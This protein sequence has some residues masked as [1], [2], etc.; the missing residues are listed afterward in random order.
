MEIPVY[1][2]MQSA[3]RTLDMENA[4][5]RVKTGI[6]GLDHVLRGGLPPHHLYLVEG[7]PGTG[8]TTV[9]LQFL[10]EGKR[11]GERGLY[12]TLSETKEEMRE[13]AQSHGWSLE[14]IDLYQLE[15]CGIPIK[16]GGGLHGFPSGGGRTHRNRQAY[17]C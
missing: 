11:L 7:P 15:D 13:V 6:P 4:K 8:K 17:L 1:R 16:A 12:V 3:M 14:G 10:L 9:A 5:S 2:E